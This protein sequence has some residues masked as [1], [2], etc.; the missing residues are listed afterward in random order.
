MKRKRKNYSANEK[1]AIL[2]RHLVDKVSVSDLCDEYQLNPTVFYRWQK[3]LLENGAVAFEKSDA[4]R[5]RAERKRV[6]ELEAKLQVKNEV[7][8]ELME[9][10]VR[11]KKTLGVP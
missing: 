2:K 6:E 11:L 9:E 3:E 10:H 7:L 8:S 1:V 4:R 5:Q